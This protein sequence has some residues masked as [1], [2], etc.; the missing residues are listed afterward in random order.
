AELGILGPIAGIVAARQVDLALALL[1]NDASVLDRIWIYDGRRD[2]ARDGQLRPAP[3]CR[4]CGP[5]THP[6]GAAE[7]MSEPPEEVEA[8]ELDLFGLTCPHT[9]IRTGRALEELSPGERLWVRLSSDEAA[10]NV[11][12]SAIAAG[13]RVLAQRSDGRVH[14][15]LL[16]RGEGGSA[17]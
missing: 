9:Y 13:H 11:P 17:H 10:R 3:D 16:E 14:R 2:A 6:R 12:K 1:K 7:G 5:H 8:R 15:V 4:R